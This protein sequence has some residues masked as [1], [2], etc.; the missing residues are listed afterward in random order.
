MIDK[1]YKLQKTSEETTF[2]HQ[3]RKSIKSSSLSLR[4]FKNSFSLSLSE[5]VCSELKLVLSDQICDH[6]ILFF[7][8][9]SLNKS[10]IILWVCKG[11][12]LG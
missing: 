4:N 2:T 10:V 11:L 12:S 1:V 5:V 8:I 9:I 6:Y 7:S 3:E